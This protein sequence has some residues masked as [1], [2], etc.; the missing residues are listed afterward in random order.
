MVKLT[1]TGGEVIFE[2]VVRRFHGKTKP[3]KW[4]GADAASAFGR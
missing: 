1:E 4:K 2:Y 3:M